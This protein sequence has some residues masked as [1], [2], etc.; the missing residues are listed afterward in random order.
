L[1]LKDHQDREGP[2][3]TEDLPDLVVQSDVLD[4]KDQQDREGPKETEGIADLLVQPDVVDLPDQKVKHRKRF[5]LGQLTA[6]QKVPNRF[7]YCFVH[8]R[9]WL[10]RLSKFWLSFPRHD[11]RDKDVTCE[12]TRLSIASF[13]N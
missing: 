9:K 10:T 4:W 6:N 8:M 11:R 7:T 13:Q 2:K 5:M 3:E 1:D 12:H